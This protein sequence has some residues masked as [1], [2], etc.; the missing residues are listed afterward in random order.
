MYVYFGDMSVS[1]SISQNTTG[2]SD[3]ICLLLVFGV[4]Q[5]GRHNKITQNIDWE[6]SLRKLH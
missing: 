1:S 4:Q 6:R 5:L 3:Y 2:L